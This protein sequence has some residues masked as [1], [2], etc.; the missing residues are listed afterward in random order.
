MDQKQQ[1]IIKKSANLFLKHGIKSVTMDD[2]ARELGVSKKTIYKYFDDKDDL[3][4]KIVKDRTSTDRVVCERARI[5]SENAIEALFS[6]SEF[7]S[8]MLSEVHS[9]V[10]FDLQKYHKTAWK[11][12]HEHRVNFVKSQ[13]KE[14]IKRGQKEG[15]YLESLHPEVISSIYISTMNALF[16]TRTFDMTALRFDEIF[17]EI[18]FFQLRGMASEEG[19]KYLKMKN[20]Q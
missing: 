9:S 19:N 11:L 15:L 8:T 5:E 17:N 6:I 18:I 14:N 7:I 20:K 13:I 1:D 4:T 12:M 10:F 16:D 3:I 2:L